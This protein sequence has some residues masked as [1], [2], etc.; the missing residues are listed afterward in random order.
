MRDTF[1]NESESLTYHPLGVDWCVDVID[2]TE[3]KDS[4]FREFLTACLEYGTLVGRQ[5]QGKMLQLC[6][7]TGHQVTVG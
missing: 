3:G 7:G 2:R 6:T 5:S 4:G 1:L